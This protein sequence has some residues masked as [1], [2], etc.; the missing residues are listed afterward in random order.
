VI[1]GK[2]RPLIIYFFGCEFAKECWATIH[3]NWDVYISTL[4]GQVH[5]SERSSFHPLLH[6]SNPDSGMGVMESKQ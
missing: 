4:A 1:V 5:S 6:G 3:I 2:R